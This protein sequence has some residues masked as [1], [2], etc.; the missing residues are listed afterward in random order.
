M[1][2]AGVGRGT[3]AVG[4]SFSA[5]PP[6]KERLV[7][8][9]VGRA[10]RR[11]HGAHR[12]ERGDSPWPDTLNER[13]GPHVVSESAHHSQPGPERRN[14][15]TSLLVGEVESQTSPI[16]FGAETGWRGGCQLVAASTGSTPLGRRRR[17]V[18]RAVTHRSAFSV[19]APLPPS[20]ARQ[21]CP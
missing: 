9:E 12:D 17:R 7:G 4:G 19:V 2:G 11:L 15:Q 18:G 6:C 3:V 21:N 16:L 13:R 14:A 10:S 20:S 8:D 1:L 5:Y